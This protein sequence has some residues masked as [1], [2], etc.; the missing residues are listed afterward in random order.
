M[1][2][3]LGLPVLRSQRAREL[4]ANTALNT[5]RSMTRRNIYPLLRKCD[6]QYLMVHARIGAN[7]KTR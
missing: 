7:V 5:C 6:R 2:K 3:R 1:L 4:L